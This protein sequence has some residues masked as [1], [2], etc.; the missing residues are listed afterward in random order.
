MYGYMSII[1][2]ITEE[3]DQEDRTCGKVFPG[4]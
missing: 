3:M 4:D 1:E 2:I